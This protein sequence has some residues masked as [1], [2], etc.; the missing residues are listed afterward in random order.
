MT[1][2][3]HFLFPLRKHVALCNIVLLPSP[4]K[5]PCDNNNNKSLRPEMIPFWK[6]CEFPKTILIH[7]NKTKTKI[8]I[9]FDSWIILLKKKIKY[10]F[11]VNSTMF[12]FH[13]KIDTHTHTISEWCAR[14]W[15]PSFEPL[16]YLFSIVGEMFWKSVP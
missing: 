15:V 5:N 16:L 6:I 7:L 4:L 12:T 13:T 8:I 2:P 9:P 11:C 14:S 1:F 10:N 3:I